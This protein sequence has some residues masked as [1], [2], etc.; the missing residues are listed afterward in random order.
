[1]K[2][3]ITLAALMATATLFSACSTDKKQSS[4]QDSIVKSPSGQNQTL[5][6]LK[7]F[8]GKYPQEVGLLE[9]GNVKTRLMQLL[10]NKY[11]AFIK[12]WNTESPIS[13]EKNVLGASG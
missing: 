5:D 11:A 8:A 3:N 9:N 1:M 2:L 7:T 10:G 13:I 4:G 6:S 12:S